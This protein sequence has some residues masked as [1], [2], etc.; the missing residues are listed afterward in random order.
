[1]GF[2]G[3]VYFAN[4]QVIDTTVNT[5]QYKMLAFVPRMIFTD[6][7]RD[8]YNQLKGLQQNTLVPDTTQLLF[9]DSSMY[10]TTSAGTLEYRILT[11]ANKHYPYGIKWTE[12]GGYLKALDI[13]LFYSCESGE[14]IYCYPF[15]IDRKHNIKYD[16]NIDFEHRLVGPV[17]SP[18]K[19]YIVFA[20]VSLYG[21][22]K[23]GI[24]WILRKQVENGKPLYREHAYATVGDFLYT[25]TPIEPSIY[26]NGQIEELLWANDSTIGVK[27]TVSKHDD[28]RKN[29][30][31]NGYFMGELP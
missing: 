29:Y 18:S 12:Y 8:N 21:R 27:I 14:W 31:S 7:G 17:V 9:Q 16:L 3:T 26:H 15:L 23:S 24:I 5:G 2:C 20:E 19:E 30:N 10:L 22:N 28:N 13:L 25:D 1:M 4:A 11:E 6:I